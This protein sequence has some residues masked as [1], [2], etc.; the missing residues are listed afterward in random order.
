MDEEEQDSITGALNLIRENKKREVFRDRTQMVLDKERGK[1][2]FTRTRV[3]VKF[4]DG[5]V[6]EGNFGAKESIGDIY[7]WVK[8]NIAVADDF[9]LFETPPKRKL[10]EMG[11]QLWKA[12]FVPSVLL[13]FSW[14]SEENPLTGPYLDIGRL[15]G[16]VSAF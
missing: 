8:E 2:S 10:T 15:K 16:F 5:F 7:A 12:K 3:R 14:T 6:I 9:Y 4:P 11:K 1:P 13:Y